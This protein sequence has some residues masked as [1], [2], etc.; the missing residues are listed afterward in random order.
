M[1]IEETYLDRWDS[2]GISRGQ[3]IG[4]VFRESC[5]HFQRSVRKTIGIY[6]SLKKDVKFDRSESIHESN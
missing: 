2:S 4:D 6:K 1:L 3:E 5:V